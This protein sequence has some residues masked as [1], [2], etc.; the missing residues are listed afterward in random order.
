MRRCDSVR[1]TAVGLVCS[2]AIGASAAFAQAVPSRV[3]VGGQMHVLRL[4]ESADTN[5][6]L[7]GRVTV[8]LAPWLGVEGEYQFLPKDEI[9]TTSVTA[10]GSTVGLRYE[11]RRSTSLFGVKA[12]YRGERVGVFAKV[13][14][15]FTS[16]TDRGVECLGDVCA[17]LLLAVPDYRP[18][19]ALDVGGVVELY[20]SP[21]WM[22]RVDVGSLIVKHR[23]TAP[24]CPA[25]ECT[26]SNLATSVGVGMR[27]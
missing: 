8:N 21:R 16:L 24:P 13:R 26:T 1:S 23:S 7:G 15:G 18:E 9:D 3:E 17:L 22:A 12:G 14:P 4:S 11:R 19:F 6:G 5:V 10:D 2:L 20:P 27:F 25:G